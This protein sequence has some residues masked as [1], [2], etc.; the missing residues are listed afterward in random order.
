MK[1][2]Q[3]YLTKSQDDEIKLIAHTLSTDDC[4]IT[5]SDVI[6]SALASALG[7][8][9]HIDKD[10]LKAYFELKVDLDVLEAMDPETLKTILAV[11]K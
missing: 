9:Q 7:R 4:K 6:R 11:M 3:V 5:I 2:V 8:F 10:V 1:L